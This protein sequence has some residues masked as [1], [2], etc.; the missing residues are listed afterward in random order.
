MVASTCYLEFL[1][2]RSSNLPSIHILCY[3]GINGCLSGLSGIGGQQGLWQ[4]FPVLILPCL[5]CMNDSVVAWVSLC[6]VLVRFQVPALT[7]LL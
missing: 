7:A 6:L 3:I 4:S 2:S 5:S 1:V